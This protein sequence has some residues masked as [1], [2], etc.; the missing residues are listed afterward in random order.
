M[1]GENETLAK[2]LKKYFPRVSTVIALK[3]HDYT[4][5]ENKV[6]R[7]EVFKEKDNVTV[8][9]QTDINLQQMD[10]MIK[11]FIDVKS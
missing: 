4:L 3:D 9:C 8:S 6:H 11:K 10:D 7:E 1:S 5:K 2:T